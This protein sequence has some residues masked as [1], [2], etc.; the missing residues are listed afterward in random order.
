MKQ[1]EIEREEI[2]RILM[3]LG[4]GALMTFGLIA[5]CCIGEVLNHI[6]F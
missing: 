6:I 4:L 2:R 3:Q 5:C 1:S